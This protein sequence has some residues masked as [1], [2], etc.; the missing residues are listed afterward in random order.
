IIL[1]LWVNC[2]IGI[3]FYVEIDLQLPYNNQNHFFADLC[4]SLEDTCNPEN[5]SQPP[6]QPLDP[7]DK[8][9]SS[10]ENSSNIS[11]TI[12]A[13]ANET[14]IQQV[15]EQIEQENPINLCVKKA[16]PEDEVVREVKERPRTM[17]IPVTNQY[18]L[19]IQRNV[20]T[21]PSQKIVPISTYQDL[22]T[23][24]NEPMHQTLETQNQ[25]NTNSLQED[26]LRSVISLVKDRFL[27]PFTADSLF[28][29]NNWYKYLNQCLIQ[30]KLGPSFRMS[31]SVLR[32]TEDFVIENL[33]L[34][35]CGQ[36]TLP[37]SRKFVQ[38]ILKADLSTYKD[39]LNHLLSRPNSTA[40][41]FS[42]FYDTLKA[43]IQAPNSS[44]NV[45]PA[46]S[47]SS[48]INPSIER[49]PHSMPNLN[50]SMPI[51]QGHCITTSQQPEP[52]CTRAQSN[53]CNATSSCASGQRGITTHPHY[54]RIYVP[55][56]Y[57]VPNTGN[58]SNGIP[59]F[60]P[61]QM[62]MVN[63][64]LLQGGHSEYVPLQAQQEM[65]MAMMKQMS[66]Y[67]HPASQGMQP[68]VISNRK[69]GVQQ[70][71]TAF[72]SVPEPQQAREN[73]RV[74]PI[75]IPSP[76][77][78]ANF[79]PGRPR[80][81]RDYVPHDANQ[82]VISHP[83]EP[84]QVT[85][86]RRI[87][88]KQVSVPVSATSQQSLGGLGFVHQPNAQHPMNTGLEQLR[89]NEVHNPRDPRL[90]SLTS[91]PG[92][93]A[94]SAV[95]SKYS[96]AKSQETVPMVRPPATIQQRRVSVISSTE[97]SRH[98]TQ[99]TNP[100]LVVPV[101]HIPEASSANGWMN[102]NMPVPGVNQEK[103][104][105][106][107]SGTQQPRHYVPQHVIHRMAVSTA[108]GVPADAQIQH[109]DSAD[110]VRTNVR[111]SGNVITS[112]TFAARSNAGSSSKPCT[113]TSASITEPTKVIVSTSQW[114]C[115]AQNTEKWHKEYAP[116]VPP[117]VNPVPENGTKQL[118][119]TSTTIIGNV[120]KPVPTNISISSLG[121][122]A[123]SRRVCNGNNL[124]TASDSTSE[125]EGGRGSHGSS[126]VSAPII[127]QDIEEVIQT[128][129]I[130][131]P[132]K[133]MKRNNANVQNAL[134]HIMATNNLSTRLNEDS[135]LTVLK[136][137][138]SKL[139]MIQTENGSRSK[140]V[141]DTMNAV[142]ER[143]T[144]NADDNAKD[145][146]SSENELRL[147]K[148]V[149]RHQFKD[150]YPE[151]VRR[152]LLAKEEQGKLING[153]TDVDREET[154]SVR[155]DST[156]SMS[157]KRQSEVELD[158]AAKRVKSEDFYKGNVNVEP[159]ISKSYTKSL[160]PS[161]P[162]IEDI[163]SDEDTATA[164]F[165]TNQKADLQ[166]RRA[167]SRHQQ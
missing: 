33:C 9:E 124:E 60:E 153:G 2:E 115:T 24:T 17:N 34:F 49:P 130:V 16:R 6:D 47:I 131:D 145:L 104:L 97:Q 129:V 80:H 69:N 111:S 30:D 151:I 18:P 46:N 71:S 28:I 72:S 147:I 135:Q 36:S 139:Q 109:H 128:N 32:Q 59:S 74:P 154:I 141:T 22:P 167:V 87:Y 78:A 138:N 1:T 86:N 94:Q 155:S 123:S 27:Y 89:I 8:P 165:A 70:P 91:K 76:Y 95:K 121:T 23:C 158:G 92:G 63:P 10:V 126:T 67:P 133:T 15:E 25:H 96:E 144:R 98:S 148:E 88:P 112:T 102:S 48:N 61:Q 127:T 159:D 7:I 136:H 114:T 106:M 162:I 83:I 11:P 146:N 105:P 161:L 55:L 164:D 37:I 57:P 51:S 82:S 54:Q 65:H 108:A 29:L 160:K 132:V 56:D 77:V 99:Q 52:C 100:N 4:N 117:N 143:G 107:D 101:L 90:M 42:R 44:R 85:R 149:L 134:P 152:V 118:N 137:N 103:R 41:W 125:C 116:T 119:T 75:D 21:K 122:Q 62:S 53:Y 79:K 166:F 68:P 5:S 20:P 142:E 12:V 39:L 156:S 43:C 66:R 13:E 93:T 58:Y 50:V 26:I 38:E 3:Q 113:V 157:P 150:T 81:R 110:G 45:L 31:V 73:L 120:I 163:S 40:D 35:R 64:S 14:A 140:K 84:H 19:P